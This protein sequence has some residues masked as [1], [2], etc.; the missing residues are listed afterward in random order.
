MQEIE[1]WLNEQVYAQ[2]KI[3]PGE[4]QTSLGFWDTNRSRN[5]GQMTRYSDS[6]QK[7]ELAE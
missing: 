6:Q 2:P 4:T 7:R 3:C 5:L 1:I